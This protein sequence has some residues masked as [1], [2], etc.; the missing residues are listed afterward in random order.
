MGA[1]FSEEQEN[2]P[3][4]GGEITVRVQYQK[5]SMSEVICCVTNF[6]N[7]T[8]HKKYL[9]FLPSN[10]VRIPK[11]IRIYFINLRCTDSIRYC[12]ILFFRH[13]RI[14]N[15][16]TFQIKPHRRSQTSSK[17]NGVLPFIYQTRAQD[18]K[19]VISPHSPNLPPPAYIPLLFSADSVKKTQF[20]NKKKR[21]KKG[22]TQPLI[23]FQKL[24]P[25][26][27]GKLELYIQ[28]D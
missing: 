8:K 3:I 22:V 26:G 24:E 12:K 20:I 19:E 28:T 13:S 5:R 17:K 16:L 11:T 6:L 23:F 15:N 7:C 9:L 27:G 4:V 10:V 1:R 21:L 2:A 18:W 25:M 14:Q